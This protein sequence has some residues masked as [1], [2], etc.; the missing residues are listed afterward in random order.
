ML[1]Q[2]EGEPIGS[3]MAYCSRHQLYAICRLIDDVQ[4]EIIDVKTGTPQRMLIKE[5]KEEAAS[6]NI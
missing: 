4:A 6:W 2:E 3:Y 1:A 5:L